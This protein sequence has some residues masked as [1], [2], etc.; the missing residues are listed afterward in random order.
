MYTWQ[1]EWNVSI[2]FDTWHG[3]ALSSIPN[4]TT[5]HSKAKSNETKQH[6]PRP[7][8]KKQFEMKY[9]SV[10]LSLVFFF[11]DMVSICSPGLNLPSS[12]LSLPSAGIV[13]MHHHACPILV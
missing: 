5:K 12:C 1:M 3:E 7:Q 11:P 8:K 9:V 4:P 13:G 6:P 2:E 10:Y